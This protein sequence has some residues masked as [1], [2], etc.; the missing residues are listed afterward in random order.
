M[1]LKDLLKILSDEC[2][3]KLQ[4]YLKTELHDI[5]DLDYERIYL[6]DVDDRQVLARYLDYYVVC[7]DDNF[8]LTIK[9]YKIA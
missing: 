1:K 4:V 8:N 9:G 5:T 7:M 6:G 2:I 3:T